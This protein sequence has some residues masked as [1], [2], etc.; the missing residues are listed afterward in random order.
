[1]YACAKCK[2][3]ACDKGEDIRPGNCPMRDEETLA[4]VL[5]E[6]KA[7]ENQSFFVNAGRVEAEGYC[8]WNRIREIIELCKKMGYGKIGLAFCV[9]LAKEAAVFT[10]LL[11]ERGITVVSVACKN[12]GVDKTELGIPEE[13]K[14]EP[15]FEPACNPIGQARYLADQKVDFAVVMGLC[16]GHDSLF[17]K[18]FSRFSDAFITTAV[19]KDRALGHNPCIAIYHAD[20]YMKDSF[21][22]KE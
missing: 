9:G 21:G 15:G 5:K 6:Y 17:Y 10:R 2:V 8:K 11:E 3:F 22:D 18:Y 7:E 4:S 14:I 16:V 1:M 13:A 12:G 20:G 19:V